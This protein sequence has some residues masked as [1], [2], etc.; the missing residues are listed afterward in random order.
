MSVVTL[1]KR[2]AV[3]AELVREGACVADVGCD[4]GKL[5]A[6]LLLSGKKTP[7][8][9]AT[10]IRPLPLQKAKDL[11]NR[12]GM[13][14]K[15]ECVLTDGLDGIPGNS[16]DD[17]VI[18]G[19]GADVITSVIHRCAWLYDPTKRL[20]LIPA[21]K[22]ERLRVF[23]SQEGFDT[24]SETAVYEHGHYYSVIL[25]SYSGNKRSISLREKWLGLIDC[26]ERTGAGYKD[27]VIG[28]MMRIIESVPDLDNEN[29]KEAIAFMEEIS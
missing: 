24:L 16:V 11:L 9:Y 21:S 15:S 19:L 29:R 17:V 8:V 6:F 22:N 25:A 4:H 23:L 18:A 5:S 28:R 12:I 10:D 14:D 26:R 7:F 1:S 27:L 20:I 3:A 13:T 2:L